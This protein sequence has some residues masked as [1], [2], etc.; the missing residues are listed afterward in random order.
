MMRKDIVDY[1]IDNRVIKAYVGEG[2]GNSGWS[3]CYIHYKFEDI[4]KD[5]PEFIDKL[6]SVAVPV[7]DAKGD[8]EVL[9]ALMEL[10]CSRSL[11]IFDYKH[12]N[13]V[14]AWLRGDEYRYSRI[15]D[16]QKTVISLLKNNKRTEVELL[17]IDLLKG[18]F[19]DSYMESTRKNWGPGGHEGSQNQ[20][21]DEY[22]L[23]I[24]AM[25]SALDFEKAEWDA[26]NN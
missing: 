13:K 22:R 18:K 24:A 6:V 14:S 20:E 15:V 7:E 16:V 2:K 8:P 25:T 19:I 3:N 10:R 26:E 4:L 17:L 1:I 9:E 23:L 21:V 12:P 11:G 5:L